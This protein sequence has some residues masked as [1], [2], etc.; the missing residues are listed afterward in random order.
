MKKSKNNFTLIELLVVIAIIAILAA[1]LLPALNRAREKAKQISCMSNLKQSGQAIKIYLSDYDDY[2]FEY[3]SATGV[4][5]N[6]LT[7][8]KYIPQAKLGGSPHIL[9]CPATQK[10]QYYGGGNPLS[11]GSYGFGYQ[12]LSGEKTS[13]FNVSFSSIVVLT[14]SRR[15]R[16]SATWENENYYL[17]SRTESTAYK[18]TLRHS[19]GVNILWLDGHA[20]YFKPP[21]ILLPYENDLLG[22][23]SHWLGIK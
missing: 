7:D 10:P 5:P 4:W 21:N 22:D 2:F 17:V 18:L 20:S 14:E 11:R 9:L 23:S 16:D 19:N 3:Y 12:G 13:R 6:L 1:M 15:Y 8:N